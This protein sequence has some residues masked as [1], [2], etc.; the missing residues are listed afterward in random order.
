MTRPVDTD[1]PSGHRFQQG[2]LRAGAGS[3]DFI[4]QQ[5]LREDRSRLEAK[6]GRG[7]VEDRQA[8]EISRQQVAG[9]A[10]P[11]EG[12]GATPGQGF[13]EGRFPHP[14][15]VFDQQMPACDQTAQ[16][17]PHLV[18]LSQQNGAEGLDELVQLNRRLL[19]PY[20]NDSPR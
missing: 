7:W 5:H 14:W 6:A 15:T 8:G 11:L 10:D 2:A 16:R 18:L 12:K 19:E 20:K 3:I 13:S 9:E 4:R 1:A 17:Q